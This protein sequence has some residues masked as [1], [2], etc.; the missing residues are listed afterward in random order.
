MMGVYYFDVG[1]IFEDVKFV[2][3]TALPKSQDVEL[4]VMIQHGKHNNN[5]ECID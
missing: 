4:I 2:R 3:A 1:V 5:L